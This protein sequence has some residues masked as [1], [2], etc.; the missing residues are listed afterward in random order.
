METRPQAESVAHVMDF[1]TTLTYVPGRKYNE[2]VI[3]RVNPVPKAGDSVA[4]RNRSFHCPGHADEK[5]VIR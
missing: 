1:F 5:F 3:G 4:A 2:P